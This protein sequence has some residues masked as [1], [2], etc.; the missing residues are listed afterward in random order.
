MSEG[1]TDS[2]PGIV[3]ES[4]GDTRTRDEVSEAV[5]AERATQDDEVEE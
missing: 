2:D 3:E 1:G 5:E 4:L